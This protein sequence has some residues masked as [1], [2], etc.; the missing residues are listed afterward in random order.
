M[1]KLNRS[2]GVLLHI[3]SLPNDI[4]L[5][6]FSRSCYEFVD[7]LKDGNFKCWQ[8]LPFT[9]CLYDNSPYSAISSF[10][11]N[12][13]FLDI[14]EFL[15]DDEIAIFAFNKNN[16]IVQEHEKFDK[17]ID[18]IYEKCRS[19]FDTTLFEKNNKYWLDD[20]ATFKV[21]K[22]L[23][24]EVSWAD[25][26]SGLK[27]RVKTEIDDFKFKNK[28]EIDK[29]IFVQ[30]LLDKQWC[31]IKKYANDR[32]IEIFG[33][34]PFYVEF[35]S[36]DVWANPKNWQLENGKP[37]NVAGVP[38]DYFNQEGQLWGNPIY[39]FSAMS[40]NK[41][42]FWVK[43]IK[44]L[45]ELF[46][47]VRIDHFVA[48][49]RYWSIPSNSNSAKNGKWVKGVGNTLLKTLTEKTKVKLVAEDLGIVTKEVTELKDKF[50]IPG[51]K[52]MQFA[53]D[54]VGDNVYQPHN[55]EKDCVAYIGT[56]DND[57]FMGML[58]EGN[59]D[60]INRFKRYLG[61]PIEYG[62]DAV[63]DGAILALYRSSA[64]MIILTAQDILKLDSNSRMNIPGVPEGN[65]KWQLTENLDRNLCYRFRE[66]SELYG[67]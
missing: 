41:Y 19:K 47:I 3:T 31:A 49:S 46:D 62:N 9:D 10:A 60:K 16:D 21:I 27:N 13:Y 12:P 18:L 40:K 67:R 53:F 52:V 4:G 51:I 6:C 57:T 35:D 63:V 29:I 55:Y 61:I 32:D 58:N 66:L 26:P 33:D 20:Y 30:Y 22:K 38:P 45:G 5:G 23:H 64:N 24:N 34:L 1:E 65:W 39:D 50:N 28:K 56:H 43:R 44:R 36:S 14:R 59:W 8:T 7:F 37:K 42:D 17:A 54:G 25:Y 48:F 15:S 2:S 11:I